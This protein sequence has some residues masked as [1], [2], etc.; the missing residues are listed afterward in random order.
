[1]ETAAKL[2]PPEAAALPN[3]PFDAQ[4]AP[5]DSQASGEAIDLTPVKESGQPIAAA[6]KMAETAAL[7][8]QRKS[9]LLRYSPEHLTS[10]RWAVL[11]TACARAALYVL[12]A[13]LPK[14]ILFRL[15]CQDMHVQGSSTRPMLVMLK[16]AG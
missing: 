10:L 5:L 15:Q 6:S 9:K 3:F 2:A 14:E 1:M 16:P 11:S 4:E 13:C 8:D 7:A 12:S